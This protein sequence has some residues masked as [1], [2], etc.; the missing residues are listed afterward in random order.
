MC[1][2]PESADRPKSWFCSHAQ[3]EFEVTLNP[4]GT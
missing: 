3:N 4:S 2:I 1:D